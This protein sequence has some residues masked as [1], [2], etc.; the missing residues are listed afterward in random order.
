MVRSA[1]LAVPV[2][3]SLSSYPRGPRRPRR[4]A[5][6]PSPSGSGGAGRPVEISMVLRNRWEPGPA[7]PR[8]H[9]AGRLR[10]KDRRPVRVGG[11]SASYC[12]PR[13]A[14]G[15]RTISIHEVDG[16]D[17]GRR[18]PGVQ[19]GSCLK[20]RAALSDW[21]ELRPYPGNEGAD[22]FGANTGPHTRVRVC[23]V[24]AGRPPRHTHGNLGQVPAA[25]G[26]SGAAPSRSP[27]A[28]PALHGHAVSHRY[29]SVRHCAL[30]VGSAGASPIFHIMGGLGGRIRVPDGVVQ[31]EGP[32]TPAYP[33]I[34]AGPS[35]G[36]AARR[37]VRPDVRQCGAAPP[38]RVLPTCATP[39]W[40]PGEGRLPPPL[41]VPRG[42]RRRAPWATCGPS[43][44]RSPPC[45]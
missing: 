41:C 22:D 7:R 4:L 38:S 31:A 28:P 44:P 6:P 2:P 42:G 39:S 3:A 9:H 21:Y 23:G 19:G 8:P 20:A 11:A 13:T 26:E 18:P 32:P 17:A 10:D 43:S 5:G 15:T 33:S 27:P 45:R 40:P 30:P 34:Y 16:D 37:P 36:Q 14:W 24:G 29:R 25:A 35:G 1:A 12:T